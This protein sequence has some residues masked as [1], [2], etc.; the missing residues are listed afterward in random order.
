[1]GDRYLDFNIRKEDGYYYT[2]TYLYYN[3]FDDFN[4]LK[5][6]IQFDFFTSTSN[7][8]PEEFLNLLRKTKLNMSYYNNYPIIW[9]SRYGQ[10]EACKLLLAD[11][12]VDP[13][14]KN[15][16]AFKSA[17]KYR[18]KEIVKL[19]ISDPRVREK[20]TPEDITRIRYKKIDLK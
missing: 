20:L 8:N 12:R 16:Q 9:A 10:L 18:H 11:P 13:S 15:N 1:M 2:H 17:L 19:L 4:D 7:H 14:D 3:R 6:Y 5:D